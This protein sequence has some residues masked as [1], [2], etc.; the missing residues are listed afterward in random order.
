[1]QREIELSKAW[2]AG[3]F[4]S[5]RR[6][7][8]GRS[9]QIVYP[10]VWS[11]SDG[12]DFHDAMIVIDGT[13]ERGAVELHLRSNSWFDH[14]HQSNIAYDAVVLHVI[15][16][17]DAQNPIVRSDGSVIPT[18]VVQASHLGSGAESGSW[19]I[20]ANLG[21]RTCLPTL[22]RRDPENIRTAIRDRGWSRLVEKQLR[23]SQDLQRLTPP[24]TLYRG[25]LDALGYS[26]N[27]EPM[28]KVGERL[29]LELI[30]LLVREGRADQVWP[31][32]LGVGGLIDLQQGERI[33]DSSV[34]QS[35]QFESVRTRFALEPLGQRDWT[36]NRV[37]PSNHPA[38][39]LASLA[40]LITQSGTDGLFARFI[41]LPLDGGKNWERWLETAHPAIGAPRRKQIMTNI[42]APFLAAYAE[43]T[44][45]LRLQEDV[46][47]EWDKLPGSVSDRIARSTR[48]QIVGTSRFPIR[49]ALEEQGLHEIYRAGCSQLRCFECPIAHLATRFEPWEAYAEATEA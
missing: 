20:L 28:A 4:S 27:R 11:N 24:E 21:T 19:K 14:G 36:L 18:L 38:R 40:S 48:R 32:L 15:L 2:A 34:E 12:P 3:E 47:A 35:K 37:R 6:L 25:L 33:F 16:H 42:F 23:F 29:P 41:D 22:P 7:T 49:T 30:E 10:G 9:I 8:D 39:R 46:A 13:L 26:R 17:D 43:V 1:M 44:R 31:A 5:E 45:D